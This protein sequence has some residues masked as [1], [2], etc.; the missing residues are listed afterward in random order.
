MLQASASIFV[1]LMLRI[2]HSTVIDLRNV[3]LHRSNR[4]PCAGLKLVDYGAN[5]LC[6]MRRAFSEFPHFIGQH[7]EAAARFSGFGGLDNRMDGA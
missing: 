5:G 7:G 2:R 3:G 1:D 6:G 4:L